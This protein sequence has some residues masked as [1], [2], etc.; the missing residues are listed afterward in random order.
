MNI[1]VHSEQADTSEK[2]THIA[3]CQETILQLQRQVANSVTPRDHVH[4]PHFLTTFQPTNLQ[5]QAC[6]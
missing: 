1:I 6:N 5:K 4:S 2:L 3:L